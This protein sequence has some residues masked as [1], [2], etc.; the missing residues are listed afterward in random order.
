MLAILG[1]CLLEVREYVEPPSGSIARP[2]AQLP[3]AHC[4]TRGETQFH[5]ARGLVK[6][7]TDSMPKGCPLSDI[8]FVRLTELGS[9]AASSAEQTFINFQEVISD[10]CT[11][12]PSGKNVD[13]ISWFIDDFQ[14][15]SARTVLEH[16]ST[17]ARAK[18]M[19]EIL[20]R[21]D[22]RLEKSLKTCSGAR[23]WGSKGNA[24]ECTDPG[25]Q[26]DLITRMELHLRQGVEAYQE[27]LSFWIEVETLAGWMQ[28]NA[29]HS[30]RL[31]S[32]EDE[33]GIEASRLVFNKIEEM[34][35]RLI[36]DR[37]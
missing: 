16:S 23:S 24:K 7:C 2:F 5:D 4:V 27:S 33:L 18:R 20:E 32:R 13:Q 26:Q 29:S 30:K 34:W 28:G 35:R 37:G 21:E 1:G 9:E 6:K 36:M 10:F 12:R 3:V 14:Q 8:D 22:E 15:E 17:I 31:M 11:R 25:V 19:K